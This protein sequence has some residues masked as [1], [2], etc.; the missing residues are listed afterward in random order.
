MPI[1]RYSD[2]FRFVLAPTA[3][4]AVL[5]TVMSWT[6]VD[7]LLADAVYSAGGNAWVW[8]DAWLTNAVIHDGG[9]NLVAVLVTVLLGT[10][11]L[12]FFSRRAAR[13]RPY[14]IYLFATA[15]V[16]AALI[17][18]LKEVTQVDC[19]WDIDRYGGTN[20]YV[21]LFGER[22][23]TQEP[24]RCFPAGHASAA[25]CWLGL[26]FIAHHVRPRWRLAALLTPV[27]LGVVFGVAQQ[28]RGAHFLSHDLWTLYLCWMTAALMY[29]AMFK[30]RWRAS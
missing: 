24:G 27:S 18:V 3:V 29:L 17:N 9:R 2:T 12:S 11:G 6:H 14:L 15:F 26:F 28:L 7:L 10:L 20:A 1:P 21:S 13:W 4:F 19:P 30:A 22:P 8:R 16:A 25:Y 5:M 23:S